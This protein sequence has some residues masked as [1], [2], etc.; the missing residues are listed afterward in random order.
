MSVN[1][2]YPLVDGHTFCG[3]ETVGLRASEGKVEEKVKAKEGGGDGA[4][5]F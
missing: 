5:S 3:V 1:E 4:D 2:I